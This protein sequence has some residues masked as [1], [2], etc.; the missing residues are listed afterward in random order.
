[1]EIGHLQKKKVPV[2]A[3][4]GKVKN[5][6]R[7]NHSRA[8]TTGTN[9]GPNL[10]LMPVISTLKE[11]RNNMQTFL[12]YRDFLLSASV[13]DK[14]RCWKQVIEA[15]QIIDVLDGKTVSWANHPAVLMWAG[16]ND[17][18]KIYFNVFLQ[19]CIEDHKINTKYLPYEDIPTDTINNEPWWLGRKK[20]HRGMRARLIE[21]KPEFYLPL[22]PNDEGYNE[23]KYWW[24]VMSTQT[25]RKI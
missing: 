10:Y 12:P 18:L 23:G 5:V 1:M 21:K 3:G 15:K 7:V 9:I 11:K 20:F 19:V 2:K 17:L 4:C 25:F 13:L 24:P 14:Q 16:Y 6:N 8:M 22:F